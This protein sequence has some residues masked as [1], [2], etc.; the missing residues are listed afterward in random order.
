MGENNLRGHPIQRPGHALAAFRQH[1]QIL[2]DTLV[3]GGWRMAICG[4]KT[5]NKGIVETVRVNDR[6]PNPDVHDNQPS[7]QNA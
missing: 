2:G 3:A 6:L 4:E 1:L 5:S 7:P